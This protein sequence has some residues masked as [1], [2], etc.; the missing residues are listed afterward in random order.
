MKRLFLI[1]ISLLIGS[2]DSIDF[3]II[4]NMIKNQKI[5]TSNIVIDFNKG[6]DINFIPQDPS[7]NRISDKALIDKDID[8][9][10]KNARDYKVSDLNDKEVVVIET[11]KG[12]IKIKLFNNVA[13]KHCLN[14]KKL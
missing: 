13:P 12:V 8:E 3:K 1:C 6:M 10:K 2:S 4:E 14:F 7:K 5:D 11:S 9:I